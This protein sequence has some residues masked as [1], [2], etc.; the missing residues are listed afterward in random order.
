MLKIGL[1]SEEE[2]NPDFPSTG[3]LSGGVES[4]HAGRPVGPKPADMTHVTAADDSVVTAEPL[5]LGDGQNWDSG[6]SAPPAQLPLLNIGH[7][8]KDLERRFLG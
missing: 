4:R 2:L 1:A 6:S 5:P 3:E 7:V 8:F